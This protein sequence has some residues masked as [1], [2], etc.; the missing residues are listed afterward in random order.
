MTE[1][2]KRGDRGEPGEEG[3]EGEKVGSSVNRWRCKSEMRRDMKSER[4]EEGGGRGSEE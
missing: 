3:E 4:G 1:G 2:F